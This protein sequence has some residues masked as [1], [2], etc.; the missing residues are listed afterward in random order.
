MSQTTTTSTTTQKDTRVQA[1]Q[2][3]FR[4]AFFSAN[5]PAHKIQEYLLLGTQTLA[6][7]RDALFCPV[8]SMAATWTTPLE[9]A[10]RRHSALFCINNCFYT[11]TRDAHAVDYSKQIEAAMRSVDVSAG[12]RYNRGTMQ[13]TQLKDV[14]WR[15]NLPYPFVH[16]G[17]CEHSIVITDIR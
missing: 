10:R 14:A 15:V 6:D 1:S 11:D 17:M 5:R 13:T 16:Q 3:L 12:G 8:D 4:V 2:S 9:N 7:L